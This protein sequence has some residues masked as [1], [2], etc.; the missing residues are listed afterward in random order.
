MTDFREGRVGAQDGLSLYYRDYGD[1]ASAKA[2]LICLTG[3]TRNAKDYHDFARRHAPKR[4]VICVDYRGRGRSAHDPNW[5]NYVPPTYVGDALAVLTALDI[6]HVVSVGTSLGGILT[7]GLGAARPAMLKAAIL[8][9]VGPVIDKDGL[10]RIAGYVGTAVHVASLEEGAARLK[11][12]FVGAYPDLSDDGW[13]MR[14]EQTFI[15]Q[16]DGRYGL[17]YDL[18]LGNAVREAAAAPAADLWPLFGTLKN[19]PTLAIRGLLSDVLSAE[20]FET[21]KAVHPK[22]VPVLVRNRGHVP[23]LDEPDCQPAIDRFL[24]EH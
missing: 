23:L 22:L 11:A 2:P 12:Q 18:N 5:R 14:A 3:L 9:D 1:R 20:V 17:D 19:I 4:R 24:D 21:M 7:M 8:N 15:R 6:G 13:L 10:A 16:A